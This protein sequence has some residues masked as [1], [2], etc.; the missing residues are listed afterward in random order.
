MWVCVCVA[1]HCFAGMSYIEKNFHLISGQ[2][3][4]WQ[5]IKKIQELF[6]IGNIIVNQI[7][8]TVMALCYAEENVTKH[9]KSS[10]VLVAQ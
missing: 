4:H 6:K 3:E 7:K 2:L 10:G 8:H 9:G 5:Q 1:S